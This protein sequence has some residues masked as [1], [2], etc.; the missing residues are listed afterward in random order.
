M[1]NIINSGIEKAVSFFRNRYNARMPFPVGYITAQIC[2]CGLKVYS[3]SSCISLK[4]C[5]CASSVARL[6]LVF[7]ISLVTVST[8]PSTSM[9]TI[10]IVTL[11]TR[12][13]PVFI[14]TGKLVLVFM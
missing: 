14:R 8:S 7:V 13:R 10:A 2:L 12:G 1:I 6:H 9:A 3:I 11:P 4:T 5:R